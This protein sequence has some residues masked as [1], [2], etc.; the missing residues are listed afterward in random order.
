MAELFD[1][2]LLSHVSLG[3]IVVRLVD[4]GTSLR[5]Y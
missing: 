4:F 2:E 5:P 3:D 1:G